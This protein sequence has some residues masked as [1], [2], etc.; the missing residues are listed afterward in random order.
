MAWSPYEP[1]LLAFILSDGRIGQV[2]YASKQQSEVDESPRILYATLGHDLEAW[3]VIWSTRLNGR[4]VYSGGDDSVLAFTQLTSETEESLMTLRDKTNYGAGVTSILPLEIDDGREILLTGSY[5][6]TIRV[7]KAPTN[8]RE[9]WEVLVEENLGGGVWRLRFLDMEQN[10][11]TAGY[12]RVFIILASCMHAGAKVLRVMKKEGG[13]WQVGII[14]AF[15]EHESMN[16]AGDSRT[17]SRE[18][19]GKFEE[20]MIVVSS[21]FYDRRICAWSV[22]V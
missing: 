6:D 17:F 14:M 4:A 12:G 9:T 3:T 8:A 11:S 20:R 1:Q 21:S 19:Q 15:T 13:G 18:V 22:S 2:S 10:R 7:V 16:Y 5:D